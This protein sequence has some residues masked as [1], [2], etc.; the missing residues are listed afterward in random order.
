MSMAPI[1]VMHFDTAFE[2]CALNDL[3]VR[4]PEASG[5]G[6]I[7]QNDYGVSHVHSS[8]KASGYHCLLCCTCA[9]F[10]IGIA[11]DSDERALQG[12]MEGTSQI[13]RQA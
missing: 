8:R 13:E 1:S 5:D 4:C 11:N 10:Y 7:G 9:C 12:T 6:G 3:Y 2:F